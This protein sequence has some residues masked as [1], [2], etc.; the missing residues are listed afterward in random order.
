MW[1]Q[2]DALLAV[3]KAKVFMN[4]SSPKERV[5]DRCDGRPITPPIPPA[6]EPH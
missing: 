4:N 2:T 1:H 6:K 5:L 3:S